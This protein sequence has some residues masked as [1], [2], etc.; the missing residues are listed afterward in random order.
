MRG[1][2]GHGRGAGGAHFSTCCSANKAKNDAI[3][4]WCS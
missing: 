3:L 2:G 1:K 4:A